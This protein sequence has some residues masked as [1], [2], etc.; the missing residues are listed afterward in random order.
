MAVVLNAV[1]KAMKKKMNG[2]EGVY[3]GEEEMDAEEPEEMADET[4]MPD[5]LDSD[6]EEDLGEDMPEGEDDEGISSLVRSFMKDERLPKS[7]MKGS[8]VA[9]GVKGKLPPKKKFGDMLKK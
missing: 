6:V 1:K 7:D 9:V 4:A 5:A 8:M 2:E 3:A